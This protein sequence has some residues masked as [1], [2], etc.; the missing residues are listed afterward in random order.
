VFEGSQWSH[1][2]IVSATGA[3][4]ISAQIVERQ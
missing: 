3:G 2:S 4:S 1:V